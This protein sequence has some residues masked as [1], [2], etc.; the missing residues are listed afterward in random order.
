MTLST[1]LSS[2]AHILWENDDDLS[3]HVLH[4]NEAVLKW[5][6][7]ANIRI[8]MFK[9]YPYLYEGALDSEKEYLETY[10][11]S[12]NTRLLAIFD[13]EDLVG[14]SN[15][16]PLNEEMDSIQKAFKA[17]KIDVE[18]YLY[19]GEVMLKEPFRGQGLMRKFMEFHEERAKELGK[20]FLTF[21]TIKRPKDHPMRPH[22]YRDLEPIWEHFGFQYEPTI[23]IEIPW[24]QIDTG[25]EEANNLGVWVKE[26]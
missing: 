6:A 18:D 9:E 25:K 21:M 19:I 14:F 5:E 7:F 10:F 26:I 23:N 22:D 17:Q 13:K 1:L 2:S 11:Q 16:I 20:K 8:D 3:L 4:G 15:C 24:T 12:P